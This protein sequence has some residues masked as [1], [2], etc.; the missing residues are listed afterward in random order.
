MTDA[1]RGGSGNFKKGNKDFKKGNN[2]NNNNNAVRKGGMWKG[3]NG[4]RGGGGPRGGG[5]GGRGGGGPR[6]GGGGGG[7]G[8]R[9]GGRGGG[10]PRGGSGGGR[11]GGGNNN[12][13][14]NFKKDGK[15]GKVIVVPHRFPGV[16]LLKGKSDILV[17][18]NLVPGESVYGE[19]RYEVMGDNEKIEYR[20]WNPFRSKLG[21]CLMGGVGNMPIKPGCKV[22][23]LG[24]AN[25]TSVSHVSDMVG[26]EGVVYA[27][28][29]SHRSGRDLTNMSKKRSNVV[30]IVEDA[31]QPIKYRMLVDMV[32]VVFA[33]VAQP[34]QARIVAM[35]A[36]MF[37]KTGGWFII[38]IK[39][40]CVDSTAKPEVVF[41][42][43]MEKLKKE[44]CKPKEKLTL[45]PFHRNH[46]IVLGM[47][48]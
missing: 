38:S 22:L 26:D 29:F 48:R 45:E 47:Y 12:N 34:D 42:S 46:A 9:G 28:E 43:E 17:T 1:F 10:G 33:D 27:V 31:R 13:K 35:N 19:K 7:R 18:K 36:H 21:A 37:L 39:A 16:F 2:N 3:N 8:A 44:S 24:A 4:G 14:K 25:G 6:G 32:D 11:F 15:S 5:G 40:N 20:V 41:A 30:P 23:Y